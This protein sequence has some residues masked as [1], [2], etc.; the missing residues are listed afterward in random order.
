MIKIETIANKLLVWNNILSLFEISLLLTNI[1]SFINVISVYGSV[2]LEMRFGLVLLS[3]SLKT[4]ICLSLDGIAKCRCCFV[5]VVMRCAVRTGPSMSLDISWLWYNRWR[6]SR[7]MLDTL[8]GAFVI[9]TF[10][11]FLVCC[12]MVGL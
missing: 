5:T 6:Y 9:V 7:F 11:Q 8:I 3:L 12:V 4:N 1:A 2:Q 10:G